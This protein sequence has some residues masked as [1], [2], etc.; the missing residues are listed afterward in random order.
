MRTSIALVAAAHLFPLVGHLALDW[1]TKPLLLAFWLENTV[2]S[3]F[4]ILRVLVTLRGFRLEPN[5]EITYW[6]E[7]KGKEPLLK[8]S[9]KVSGLGGLIASCFVMWLFA[10]GIMNFLTGVAFQQLVTLEDALRFLKAPWEFG[11]V[12]AILVAEHGWA[13]FRAV[14]RDQPWMRWDPR[15][16][17]I[18][19]FGRMLFLS[20]SAGLAAVF[21]GAYREP[22]ATLAAFLLLKGGIEMRVLLHPPGPW[23][24]DPPLVGD[25]PT[26]MNTPGVV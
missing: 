13:S 24:R 2:L 25:P 23:R 21:T 1:D 20:A 11:L 18:L 14:Y 9:I 19:P 10:L 4:G 5:R 17:S 12:L 7:R 15:F 6:R 8:S 26:V 16:H 22:T 3:T